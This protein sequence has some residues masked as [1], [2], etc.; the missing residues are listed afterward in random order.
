MVRATYSEAFRAPSIF[1]SFLGLRDS[2]PE[3][4]DP[5]NGIDTDGDGAPDT[6]PNDVPGQEG[7]F[8][9]C[10][11]IPGTYQ[12]ANSQIRITQ[13][14]NINLTPETAKSKTLGVVYEPSFA[15][16][17]VF[18]L[19]YYNVKIDDVITTLGAN[20]IINS[21]ARSG[22]GGGGL[23]YLMDRD[24]SG[25]GPVVDLR[26]YT[27][28]AAKL[29]VS[30][31][32][33]V[34]KYSLDTD[35]GLF[36]FTWD[37]SYTDTY[38]FTAI[39]DAGGLTEFNAFAGVGLIGTNNDP[40]VLER[41]GNGGSLFRLRSNLSVDWSYGD[42]SV[43]YQARFIQG[44]EEGCNPALND[45]IDETQVPSG[46]QWCQYASDGLTYGDDDGGLTDPNAPYVPSNPNGTLDRRHIGSVT[47]HDT[48]V[49]YHLSDYDTTFVLG[50]QNLFDKAPP[51][52]AVAFANSFNSAYYD[53]VGRRWYFSVTKR[54]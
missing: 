47:Y 37:S 13:G 54:F 9:G 32:D 43:F 35:Y 53:G 23:C 4:N 39:N 34:T 10:A 14:G 20:T 12:Q 49:S 46:F 2:Y 29:E 7:S 22:I 19:D 11:G 44:Y 1:E 15:E 27:T 52:S 5:C 36:G 3:L 21:C 16:G 17:L 31:F 45:V 6:N 25:S 51:L 24:P 42:W 8:P 26:D 50:I 40:T 33:F 30:G 38:K 48:Q 28:N 41:N 18:T